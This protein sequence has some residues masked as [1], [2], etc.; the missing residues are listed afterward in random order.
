MHSNPIRRY[1]ISFRQSEE[2]PCPVFDNGMTH[3]PHPDSVGTLWRFHIRQR[4]T[5]SKQSLSEQPRRANLGTKK[6]HHIGFITKMNG[7]KLF[8]TSIA[9]DHVR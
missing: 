8:F 2:S 3:H 6:S 4:S 9:I 1:L 5:S 7:L